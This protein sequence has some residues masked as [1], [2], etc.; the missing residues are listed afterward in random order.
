MR[1]WIG[2]IILAL[3][4]TVASGCRDQQYIHVGKNWDALNQ[5]EAPEDTF[6]VAAAGRRK[7]TVGDEMRFT[8][9]SDRDG[10]LWVVQ[11]GPDDEVSVLYPNEVARENRIAAGETVHVPP[12]GAEWVI[13]AEPPLG[14]SIIAFVVTTG[15]T[16]LSDVLSSPE[17]AEKALRI[18]R[19]ND[20]G[21]DKLVIDTLEE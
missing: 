7:A 8:V 12:T 17:D 2:I 20:W 6:R 11:V 19:R 4:V 5:L 15:D 14:R 9:T 1:Q 21:M 18:V 10:R 16:D 3:A 13:A